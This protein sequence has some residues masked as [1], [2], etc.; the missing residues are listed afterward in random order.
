MKQIIDFQVRSG[1]VPQIG[2]HVAVVKIAAAKP[3]QRTGHTVLVLDA[4]GSMAGSISDVNRDSRRFVAELP[5]TDFVSVIVFSGHGRSKL[6]AGPTQCNAAGR[7]LVERAIEAEYHVM[8]TTVFSE[9][10]QMTLETVQRLAGKDTVHNAVLFTDGCAVPTRWGVTA[11]HE[12][13]FQVARELRAFGAVVSVIGYGVYYDHEFITQLMLEAGNTGVYKHIS[14]VEDFGSAIKVIRSVFEKTVLSTIELS[15]LAK[16]GAT[17]KRVFRTTPQLLA[18]GEDGRVVTRGLYDGEVT[19]YVEL[20]GP[21]S[22]FRI[23]GSIDSNKYNFNL[24]AN[25]LTDEDAANYVRVLGAWAFLTG[26]SATAAELLELTSDEALAE[27]ASSA[28]TSRE[29][30]EAGDT[31]RHFF[32]DRRFIGTGLKAKGPNH[33]VLHVLRTLIEDQQ[34]VVSLPKG[35][36]K[37]SG[38][39]T[40]DPRVVENPLGSTLTVVGYTS[41]ESRFNFSLRAKKDVKVL[42][43]DG[44]GAPVDAQIWR[45][46]NVILDGN[47]HISELLASLSEPSFKVLQEAGVIGEKETYQA[48][49]V[50]TLNLRNLKL[51][52][53]NWANPATLGL[54]ELLREEA[55]LEEQQKGLNARRKATKPAGDEP[56]F[57]GNMYREQAAKVEGVP[58]EYYWGRNVE[59]RLLKYKAQA[60]DFSGL[61]YAEADAE[62]KQVRQRLTVVRFLIRSITFAMEM[63]G[64]KSI[65]WGDDKTTKRGEWQK[66][67]QTATYQAAFLKR[68]TW[69]EEYVCS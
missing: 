21:A 49:R 32:V 36:Y 34:N 33:S 55:E 43:E 69:D 22:E 37:R 26:D 65:K 30:R 40:R 35:A 67:E 57:E 59:Y 52:S 14:E 17:S 31:F 28:Y 62:V 42:P 25:A 4:S 54:V 45:S 41:H 68:V 3:E 23:V 12:K 10:L 63:V 64:S 11:E 53:P 58:R 66:L 27:V 51:I 19:F 29:Q 8:D 60:Y 50:Y 13:S 24:T 9:P 39:L 56:D 47:L 44:N 15:F 46:Y 6:I 5:E 38:E 7:K 48:G 1:S 18:V 2:R 61:S 20:T 16:G